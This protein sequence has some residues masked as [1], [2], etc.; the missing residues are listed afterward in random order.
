MRARHLALHNEYTAEF[1]HEDI[2]QWTTM[3]KVWEAD[4]SKPN[5]FEETETSEYHRPQFVRLN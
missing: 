2:E 5:P 3:M 4:R 1:K